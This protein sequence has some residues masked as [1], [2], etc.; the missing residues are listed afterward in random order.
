MKK[1]IIFVMVF[2]LAFVGCNNGPA[3]SGE[4]DSDSL[5]NRQ[6]IDDGGSFNA[7]ILEIRESFVDDHYFLV[8]PLE[9][10]PIRSIADRISFVMRILG[11][12]DFSVGDYVTIRYDGFVMKSYPAQIVVIGWSK[13]PSNPGTG[14]PG[15]GAQVGQGSGWPSSS[16]LSEYSLAGWGQPEGLGGITWTETKITD[17]YYFLNINFTSAAAATR[18]GIDNF[19]GPWD[20]SEPNWMQDGETVSVT[21]VKRGGDFRYGVIVYYELSTGGYIVLDRIHE[22][23]INPLASIGFT[24][25]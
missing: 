20:S 9:G 2:G 3:N 19:L 4:N 25:R 13:V 6:F 21:Y 17:T 15:P 24:Q 8:E 11:G 16:K 10:E 14:L 7:K 22:D 18:N 1:Y 23:D 12:I 5:V